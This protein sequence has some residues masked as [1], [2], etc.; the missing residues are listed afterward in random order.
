[1]YNVNKDTHSKYGNVIVITTEDV[2]EFELPFHAINKAR[3]LKREWVSTKKIR[4]LVNEQVLSINQLDSW[5][6]N[7]YKSLAKCNMCPAILHDKNV[8][9]HPFCNEKL[10]CSQECADKDYKL[11]LEKLEDEEECDFR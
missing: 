6:H 7:E 4:F 5:A 1:M 2:G 11:Y 8:F 10:F 9:T 3:S